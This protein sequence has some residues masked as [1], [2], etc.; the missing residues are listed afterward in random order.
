[1]ERIINMTEAS[2][3]SESDYIVIDSPTLGTRKYLAAN[4]S[5]GGGGDTPWNLSF[6]SGTGAETIDSEGKFY[7]TG[8][9]NN[10]GSPILVGNNCTM[11]GKTKFES[12]FH[13]KTDTTLIG[14]WLPILGC[15]SS[16]CSNQIMFNQ[17][18]DNKLVFWIKTTQ[19]KSN[20][21]LSADTEYIIEFSYDNG[22]MSW[23]IMD[24]D[25][26]ILDNGT[27]SIS[28]SYDNTST[29]WSVFSATTSAF[30]HGWL[31]VAD[32]YIKVDNILIWGAELLT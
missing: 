23:N 28:V 22:V 29:I 27:E 32:S 24:G 13:I 9:N 14:S 17:D 15:G 25:E 2:A 12:R 20:V 11:Y 4:L 10:N 30:M 1:M 16:L 21:A 8:S 31:Y 6:G 19:R 18:S 3:I 5:G 26:T 7:R